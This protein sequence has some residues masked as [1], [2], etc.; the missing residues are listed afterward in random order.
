MPSRRPRRSRPARVAEEIKGWVVA[1]ALGPGDRLPGESEMMARFGMAKGTI[2]EAMRIL[3]AQ[4]L[5]ETRTGPGGGGFVGQV[6]TER[7]RSLLANYFYFRN[8]TVGD[9]YQVR[10][11]LEPVLAEEL[12]GRLGAA[13]IEELRSLADACAR[14]AADLDEEREQHIASLRFHARLAD[15]AGNELLGFIIGFMAEALSDITVARELFAP[16]NPELR[17]TG[18]AYQTELIAALAAGDGAAARRIMTA[19][20]ETAQRLMEGQEAKAL[21]RFM[22]G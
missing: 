8:L 7:A 1:H 20:M 9:I 18:H 21:S 2:R 19:H 3:E 11:A 14:P 6:S 12:A 16:P 5:V 15:H 13:E 22:E 4:G 10:R 17:R